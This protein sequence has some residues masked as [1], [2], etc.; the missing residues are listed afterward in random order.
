MSKKGRGLNAY[1]EK[2]KRQ[3]RRLNH[4]ARDLRSTKYRQRVVE[5]KV[6]KWDES[7]EYDD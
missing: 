7:E 1:D 5:P 3:M 6:A 2:I 4:I